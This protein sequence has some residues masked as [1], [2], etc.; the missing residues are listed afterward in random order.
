M[1]QSCTPI[2]QSSYGTRV[3]GKCTYGTGARIEKLHSTSKAILNDTKGVKLSS[4]VVTHNFH[5][6][7]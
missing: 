2:P 5:V 7:F 1:N 4:M 6:V 3:P